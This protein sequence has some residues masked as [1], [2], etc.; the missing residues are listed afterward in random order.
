M[1]KSEKGWMLS[2]GYGYPMEHDPARQRGP[3]ARPDVGCRN[4]LPRNLERNLL[5]SDPGEGMSKIGV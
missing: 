2:T 3:T 4:L 1:H 5:K